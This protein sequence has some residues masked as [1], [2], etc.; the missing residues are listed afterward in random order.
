MITA[1]FRPDERQLRQFAWIA[2]PGFCL[3]GWLALR[4][5]GSTS[6]ALG[7]AAV[8]ALV[9]VVG[10]F[11]PRAVLPVYVGLMALAYPIGF[12]VSELLLRAIYYGAFTP[13]GLLFRA[14]RRDP[15]SLRKPQTGSYWRR[16]RQ[17]TDPLAYFRQA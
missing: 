10:S 4:W 8:G 13:L 6:A 17:R 7:L 11:L 16:R 14:L 9:A 1:N 3:F 12:V 5:T 2:L 15:L